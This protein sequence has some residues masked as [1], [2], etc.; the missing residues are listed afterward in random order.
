MGSKAGDGVRLGTITL[1]DA[2]SPVL[3]LA[4]TPLCGFLQG[5]LLICFYVYAFCDSYYLRR[6]FLSNSF[7]VDVS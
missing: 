5:L 3:Y 7:E 6:P 4:V 1:V 2:A